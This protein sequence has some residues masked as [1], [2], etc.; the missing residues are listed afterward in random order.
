MKNVD[1]T[2]DVERREHRKNLPVS[3]RGDLLDLETLRDDVLMSNHHLQAMF[4]L[5]S[6][7]PGMAIGK[8]EITYG[9]WKPRCP[10]AKAQE[11]T[12]IEVGLAFRQLVFGDLSM[13]PV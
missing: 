13:L 9:L 8:G 10:A 4:S 12:E 6:L 1:E 2:S 3:A 11:P 7:H 5:P